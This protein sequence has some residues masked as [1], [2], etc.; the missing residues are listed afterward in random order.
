MERES[1]AA[2]PVEG[3]HA[4]CD[5]HVHWHLSRHAPNHKHLLPCVRVESRVVDVLGPPQLILRQARFQSPGSGR[6]TTMAATLDLTPKS[7]ARHTE[8]M[9][10]P[11]KML[12]HQL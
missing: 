3:E 11:V 10:L 4:A 5:R 2:V 12:Q 7:D 9:K 6:V 8:R 1:S